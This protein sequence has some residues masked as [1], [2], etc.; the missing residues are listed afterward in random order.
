MFWHSG[1][2]RIGLSLYHILRFWQQLTQ[3]FAR[4]SLKKQK[5][6]VKIIVSQ[7][8]RENQQSNKERI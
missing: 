3:D 6:F 2:L 4:V 5:F 7:M 8:K 1:K